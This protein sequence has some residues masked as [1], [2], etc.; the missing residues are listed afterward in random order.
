M[1]DIF[2]SHARLCDGLTRREVLRIGGLSAFGL[3][4]P[5]LI[6][7][8][9][10]AAG[11]QPAVSS[12]PRSKA[13]AK[14]C[15][16]LFLMG[17]PPQHSTWDP[18]P[19]AP[20]EVRGVFAPISTSVPGL[21]FSELL[22]E[23]ARLAHHVCV[24][25][26]MSSGDNAHSSSGYYMLT[27]RPH[28]PMNF[29]NANPGPPNDFPSMGAVVRKLN[30]VRGAIPSAVTLPHHIFNTNGSV[31]PGQDAGFL[32]QAVDPWIVNCAPADKSFR[33]NGLSLPKDIPPLRLERRQSLLAQFNQRR[34]ALLQN[35]LL[36]A[37]DADT[38]QAFDLLASGR[39]A[40]AFRIDDEPESVRERYGRSPFGQS[41]LLSRRLIE[42]GV[43]LVQVNWYRAPDEP[44][45][46][47]CWDS[48]TDE[49]QRLR[50]VLM[51]PTDR[52]YSALL[53]D[54]SQRGLLDE[55]LVVCMAEFGRSPRINAQAGR[56]HWGSVYSVALAGGGVRG[57]VAYG[58]SDD[59]GGQP[60]EGRVRPQDLTA[61]IFDRLGYRPET[62]INDTLGRPLP[63]STGEPIAAIL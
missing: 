10:L 36:E 41:V 44:M 22:P 8:S 49:A 18:K 29:E 43:K 13:P 31:W 6:Q 25:R 38:R 15:I 57:G 20:P 45:S 42:A 28:T 59:I 39:S 24:L 62:T 53:E 48:H 55:T 37:F 21:Q 12:A 23:T 11:A 63:I 26:A 46:N 1:W 52:A 58:A 35:G 40:K 7:G 5:H 4:L 16:V 54:L 61:T 3:A 27:G 33:V 2:G 60:K 9:R 47:P 19:D 51:Q 50:K 17:G 56:D 30:P 14:N 34:A 32:G